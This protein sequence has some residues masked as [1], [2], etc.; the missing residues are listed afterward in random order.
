MLFIVTPTSVKSQNVADELSYARE[1]TIP[2]VPLIFR[3]APLPLRVHRAQ[4]INFTQ[5]YDAALKAL[6][7]NL[8]GD[9]EK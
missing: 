2:I 6:I 7:E 1:K 4:A 3:E 8:R 9:F 5:D